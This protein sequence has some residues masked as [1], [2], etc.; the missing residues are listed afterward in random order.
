L[1]AERR[2]KEQR[3]AQFKTLLLSLTV[4]EF[5]VL[6]GILAGKPNKAIARLLGI[7]LRTVENRRQAVLKKLQV[8]SLAALVRL[9]S[10]YEELSDSPLF[11]VISFPDSHASPG[12]K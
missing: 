2:A 3:L 4:E 12:E 7:S 5:Q 6:E 10:E 9:I 11:P 1:D 8:K